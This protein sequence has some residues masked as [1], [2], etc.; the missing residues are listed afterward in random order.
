[1]TELTGETAPKSIDDQGVDAFLNGKLASGAL[2]PVDASTMYTIVYPQ[3]TT[4]TVNTSGQSAQSCS[5]FGGYHVDTNVNGTDV[6]YAVIPT[7]G[8]FDTLGGVDA[9][10]GPMTHELIEAVTNPYSQGNP[11]YAMVDT[12]HTVWAFL[13]GGEVGD[14]CAWNPASFYVPSDLK[15]TVQ[16]TWS[17]AMA[18]AG[19]DPCAPDATGAVYFNSAPVFP[20]TITLQL[21]QTVTTRGIT[22][23][24]GQKKTIEVDLFSDAPTNGPWTVSAFDVVAR[25][26]GSSSSMKFSWDR[27]SGVNGEKLH[28][29]IEVTGA[30][31]FGG[32]VF[33]IESTLGS[34]ASAWLGLVKN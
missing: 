8:T 27:S 1:M 10:T 28:L 15:A 2:G 3:G 21:N 7:C 26:R 4:I 16:K 19:H 31:S 30:S 18:A 17:N 23:P 12:D 13:G 6:P 34:R 32:G 24:V 5:S 33:A 11:A 20:E 9:V 22:I 25:A 29:T 14:L